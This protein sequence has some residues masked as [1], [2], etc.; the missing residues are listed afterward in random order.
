MDPADM[1]YT[2]LT[3]YNEAEAMELFREE[4][5]EEGRREGR[6]EGRRE[7]TCENLQA[8]MQS[9]GCTSEHAMDL[10]HVPPEKRMHYRN[11]A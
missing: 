5:R 7:I 8:L 11:L 4:G 6:E 2:T 1:L 10:L 3:E 9:L